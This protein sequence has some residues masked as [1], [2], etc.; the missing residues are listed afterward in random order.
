M[1]TD[2]LDLVE[3]REAAG[4]ALAVG[5]PHV[6][7]LNPTTILALIARVEAAEGN[8]LTRDLAIVAGAEQLATAAKLIEKQYE[9]LAMVEYCGEQHCEG[10]SKI[11]FAEAAYDDWKGAN[12]GK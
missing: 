10:C 12:D 3:L 1:T 4:D 5:S 7:N 9:A 11:D 8:L 2:K 6:V